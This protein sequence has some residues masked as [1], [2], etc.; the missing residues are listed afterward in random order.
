MEQDLLIFRTKRFVCIAVT[1]MMLFTFCVTI[2]Y[3]AEQVNPVQEV[4]LEAPKGAILLYPAEVL[5]ITEDGIRKIIKTYILTSAQDP[6]DIP[7]ESFTVDGINYNLTDITENRTNSTD[8]RTHVETVAINTAGNDFNEILSK[9]PS[10]LE[11]KSDDG[12]AGELALDI[13]SVKCEIEGH[14]KSNYTATATRE[15]PNLS[16]NDLSLIPKTI[17]DNNRTLALD[18]VKWEV[19]NYTNVDYE[20]IPDS[21]RA[22]AT[23]SAAAS[24]SVI[25][26]YVTTANYTGEII[27]VSEGETIYTA[28]FFEEKTDLPPKL[29]ASLF[30]SSDKAILLLVVF[31]LLLALAAAV[32]AFFCLRYNVKIFSVDDDKFT[33]IAKDKISAKK[34]SIDLS[35]LENHIKDGHF[36]L[37]ID[38]TTAKRLDK[39]L[40]KIKFDQA[41]LKHEIAYEG[42]VYTIDVDFIEKTIK[43]VY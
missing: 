12:Y 24:R 3:S 17:T 30:E 38:K 5:T 9:L 41:T 22:I 31:A 28:Y 1:I 20:N 10:T 21:Y 33:L 16:A 42:N 34:P 15:Y 13:S 18:N 37:T 14:R 36:R 4:P 25:T 23:Y 19:Q 6:K 26:G 11:Y 2:T 40:I 39:A 8:I 27:K 29:F 7:K 32:W 43:A 35:P